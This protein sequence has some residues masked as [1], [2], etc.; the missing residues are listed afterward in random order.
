[1]EEEI[2]DLVQRIR[3]F[4]HIKSECGNTSKKSNKYYNTSWSDD[5]SGRNRGKED[6]VSNLVALTTRSIMQ[7]NIDDDV[8]HHVPLD[9]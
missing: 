2:E 6:H 4:G 7:K 5:K 8:P 9:V 3:W 1:M